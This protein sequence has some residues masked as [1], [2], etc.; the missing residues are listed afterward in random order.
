MTFSNKWRPYGAVR[1]SVVVVLALV[2]AL[3]TTALLSSRS[4]SQSRDG[5]GPLSVNSPD[6]PAPAA[7]PPSDA[8]AAGS[9]S[10]PSTAEASPPPTAKLRSTV[11]VSPL[12][13]Q[14]NDRAAALAFQSI[15]AALLDE[16]RSIPNLDLVELRSAGRDFAPDDIDFYVRVRGES[17]G[18][19]GAVPLFH[20]YWTATS[21]GA[22]QWS[23]SIASSVPWTAIAVA[24]DATQAL[25]RFPFPPDISRPVELEAVALDAG[26][27]AEERFGALD[28]LKMIPQRF[29]FVGRD[30][31]RVVAVAAADIVANSADPEVRGRT[32]AAMRQVDDPYMKV[33]DPYLIEPLVD[34]ALHDDS[35]FV[36]LEAVKTLG[37]SFGRDAKARAALE[38]AL[39]HDLSPQV[40]ANAH[41]ES[42]DEDGRRAY[43]A[44]TL[45]RDDLSDAARLELLTAGV[46]GFRGYIDPR[47]AQALVDI[48]TRALPSTQESAPEESPGRVSATDVV[49]LLLE[50][51]TASP[52]EEI[53]AAVATGLM[54]HRREAGVDVALQAAARDDPSSQVREHITFLFRRSGGILR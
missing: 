2:A 47:A 52:S 1:V 29:A 39:V 50:L 6:S 22:G 35:E 30:E 37:S 53:R 38:Y 40:R 11:A 15:Y 9:A 18:G 42:L 48:A 17:R 10:T 41:W 27:S 7:A 8:P 43:V 24:R 5:A 4:G 32:W 54:R 45:L 3:A 23:A 31:R 26:R 25:R 16:L 33:D 36:R 12:A 44:G 19:P 20:V 46:S 49:P 13:L 21:G 51:L 28:E 14:T 34:S